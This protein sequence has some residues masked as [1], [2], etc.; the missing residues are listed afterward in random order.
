[1]TSRS[2]S[3]SWM[4]IIDTSTMMW[5]LIDVNHTCNFVSNE[6]KKESNRYSD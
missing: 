2:L 1:M 3:L 4:S 6:D 5:N